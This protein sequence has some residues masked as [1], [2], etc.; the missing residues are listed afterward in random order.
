MMSE[1][2]HLGFLSFFLKLPYNVMISGYDS[3]LY[4]ETLS[5]WRKESFNTT[6]RA[7]QRTTE[8]VWS[9]FKEPVELHD[10]SF[11]GENH[12]ERLDIK[13]LKKRWIKNLKNMS[14]QKRFAL[15]DA[16]DELKKELTDGPHGISAVDRCTV[17][18]PAGE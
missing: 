7:G 2:Q 17:H 6:N 10:Y 15:F 9:N 18:L 5:V 12:R 11:L 4:N 14:A 1:N 8:I 3:P 13:R 16:I